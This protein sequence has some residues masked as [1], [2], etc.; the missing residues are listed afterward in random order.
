MKK[1]LI[2]CEFYPSPQNIGSSIRTLNFVRYFKSIGTVDIA[3]SGLLSGGVNG[4]PMFSNEYSL[5]KNSE[6]RLQELLVKWI[7]IWKRPMEISS[8]CRDS[9]RRLLNLIK[10]NDYD[11]ILARY[12]VN[13]WTLFQ[14]KEKYRKRVI[15]DFDDIIS[16]SLSSSKI[17]SEPK[18]NR[19]KRLT[20][21]RRFLKNY[22][23]KCLCFGA[24][25]FCSHKDMST[26]SLGEDI[27]ENAFVVPNIFS[28]Q[29]FEGYD[30]GSGF[31]RPNDLLFVGNLAY[32][33]NVNGLKWFIESIFPDFKKKF[34]DAT[35]SIV[36]RFPTPEVKKMAENNTGVKLYADVPDTRWYYAQCRAVIVPLLCG[37]G[38]RIKILEAGLTQRPILSTRLGVDGLD[39][40]N[41][42]NILL[43]QQS[44][45]FI[46][47]YKKLF[48]EEYYLNIVR[49]A[50]ETVGQN[51]SS[52]QFNEKMNKVIDHIES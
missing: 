14:A 33:P 49:K 34:S 41:D 17:E 35:L 46:K 1:A 30:F 29:S 37:G 10:G 40:Q 22:E 19:R 52:V 8:L 50:K 43:F 47:Q 12:V 23:K 3:Y 48:D 51:Y 25:L 27:T 32:G 36:G 9:E 20:L 16:E 44:R 4:N 13:T 11:Y 21:N 26:I 5:K 24:A 15:I 42:K 45:D 38:T 7:S 6:T 2:V 18:W 31:N 39:F 28:D